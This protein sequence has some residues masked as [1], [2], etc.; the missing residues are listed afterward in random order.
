MLK[1]EPCSRL[2]CEFG[3][4]VNGDGS[5]LVFAFLLLRLLFFFTS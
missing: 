5:L 1:E 2:V 3:V 4:A